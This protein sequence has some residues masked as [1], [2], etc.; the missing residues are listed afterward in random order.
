MSV[1]TQAINP[2]DFAEAI[3]DLPLSAVYSK[4]SEL[5]NSIAHLHRSNEEL[6]LFLAESKDSEEE[7]KE[8]E[9]YVLENEGVVTS[10]N[11]RISL[12]KVEVERR[13]QTWIEEKGEEKN[14]NGE[15]QVSEETI[16]PVP[17]GSVGA[18]LG[19]QGSNANAGQ[20]EDG[21]YL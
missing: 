18:G 2:E 8:I 1:Q 4:V 19:D 6:R 14:L 17:N 13:G 9:G 15:V 20:E 10:M 21:V 7:K 3:A 12:L 16:A 5:R 11:E